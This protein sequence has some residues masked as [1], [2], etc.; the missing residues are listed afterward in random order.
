MADLSDIKQRLADNAEALAFD[1]FGQPTRRTSQKLLFGRKGSTVVNIAGRYKGNF[2]SWEADESGSMIDAIMFAIG[3]DFHE[4]LDW[5]KRWLGDGDDWTPPRPPKKRQPV[6]DVDEEEIRRRKRAQQIW[7]ESEPARGTLGEQYLHR[8][9]I[10]ADW[11]HDAVRYHAKSQSL[12]VASTAPETGETAQGVTSI[13]RIY[14]RSDGQARV[15]NDGQ[16]IKRS[17]GP[18]YKGAVRLAGNTNALCLAEGPETGLSVWSATQIE[19]WVALGQM[20]HVDLDPIPLDK[21]I[22]ICRD[23]DPRNAPVRIALRKQIK[24]WR[25]EGRTVLE[26]SPNTRSRGNKFDFNDLLQ[27]EGPEAITRRIDEIVANKSHRSVVH[28]PVEF[29]R[30]KTEDAIKSAIKDLLAGSATPIAIPVATGLGKTRAYIEAVRKELTHN[31][32]AG[33]VVIAVPTHKLSDEL[34]ERFGTEVKVASYRGRDA[35]D[36]RKPGEQMCLDLK[37]VREVQKVGGDAQTL[38]C[39]NGDKKCPFFDQCGYQRQRQQ[40][41]NVWLVS[42]AALFNIKPSFVPEPK[43]RVLDEN[44]TKVGVVGTGGTDRLFVTEYEVERQPLHGKNNSFAD[45]DLDAELMPSRKKLLAVIRSNGIGPISRQAL[46]DEGLTHDACNE[47]HKLEWKRKQEISIWPGMP[48]KERREVLASV[49]GNNN[50]VRMDRMW[51][52]LAMQLDENGPELSGNLYIAEETDDETGATQR[53]LRLQY[54]QD[55]RDGWDSPTLYVDATPSMSAAEL[56]LPNLKRHDPIQADTPH[57]TIIQYPDKAFGKVALTKGENREKQIDEIWNWTLAR[58]RE[59][60]GRWLLVCQKA[61]EEIIVDRHKIPDHIDLAHHNAVAGQDRWKDIRGMVVVGRTQPPPEA[62]RR[63]ASALTGEHIGLELDPNDWY[64][65]ITQEISAQSG[66]RRTIDIDVATHPLAEEVRYRTCEAELSQII[67]RARGVN[68]SQENPVEIHVLTNTSLKEEVSKFAEWKRPSKDEQLLAHHGIW[69]SSISDAAKV[70]KI[71]PNTLKVARQRMG[72]NSYKDYLYGTV[73]NL[74]TVEYQLIGAGKSRQRAVFDPSEIADVREWLTKH[75]G[76]LRLCE[77]K[78]PSAA[79]PLTD[80]LMAWESGT[81]PRSIAATVVGVQKDCAISQEEMAQRFGVSR[82]H[83]ANALQGRF[84]LAEDAVA[85][86]KAFLDDPPTV[87][88][89]LF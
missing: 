74:R 20:A 38:V 89:N 15:D 83:L 18:R 84:G 37:T 19:T 23:D 70:L 14:L 32:L 56:Y 39:A 42:H 44:F 68:R 46:I 13:Q 40:T 82:P 34:S 58:T 69:L 21:T 47:A 52:L 81:M 51:R 75:L 55:I 8:R 63:E 67:G 3:C 65:S 77:V 26:V 16:K 9:A 1:L 10:F 61:V 43:L 60:G 27:A 24:L 62:V 49:S 22:V 64:P 72:T 41:G 2:R 5:G 25:R 7:H 33:P 66:Q 53:V 29:A 36:P 12:V 50:I 88:P 11:P 80:D 30:I 31:P 73:P 6:F 79:P 86:I 17:L 45:A 71:S 59:T 76:E 78:K 48:K 4:A 87:Q 85:R 28:A 35:D 57:Q 54:R